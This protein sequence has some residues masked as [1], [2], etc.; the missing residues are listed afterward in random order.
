MRLRRSGLPSVRTALAAAAVLM[1]AT[2]CG[3]SSA[4]SPGPGVITV[5]GTE[6]LAWS[7]VGKVAALLAASLAA[8]TGWVNVPT[9]GDF[10]IA[11]L[12]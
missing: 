8:V 1:L 9:M 4:P 3:G 11:H 7:Q 5:R 2:A 6:R 10:P 12:A